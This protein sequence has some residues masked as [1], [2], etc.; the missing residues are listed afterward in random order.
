METL[1]FSKTFHFCLQCD[2]N[3]QQEGN[4]E[5]RAQRSNLLEPFAFSV[6]EPWMKL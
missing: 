6:L 5:I 2:Q 4:A 3:E 1:S